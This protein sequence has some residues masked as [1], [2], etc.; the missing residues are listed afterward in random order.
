[1]I[2]KVFDD[3]ETPIKDKNKND[4][5]KYMNYENCFLHFMILLGGIF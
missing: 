5:K 1:M 3:G 2:N 4:F